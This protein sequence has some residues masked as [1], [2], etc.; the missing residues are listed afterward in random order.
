[1]I[2]QRLAARAALVGAAAALWLAPQAAS[3]ASATLGHIT[4][5]EGGSATMPFTLTLDSDLDVAA[6]TATLD[7]DG[8]RIWIDLAHPLFQNGSS[9]NDL[10]AL[11]GWTV[12]ANASGAVIAFAADFGNPP[13]DPF[14]L[15]AAAP[16]SGQL[17]FTGLLAGP[18]SVP[19]SL[20]LE[21]CDLTGCLFGTLQPIVLTASGSVTVTPVPE[22]AT[23]ALFAGGLLALGQLARRRSASR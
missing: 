6:L 10:A 11:P 18:N 1:M 14:P 20:S 23:W 12:N 15:S 9:P 8:T 5:V 13:I 19:V 2:T 22:P 21:I 16:Y 3:A 17:M 7:Y 4:V